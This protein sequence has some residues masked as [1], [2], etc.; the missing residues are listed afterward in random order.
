[1][2]HHREGSV[3]MTESPQGAENCYPDLGTRADTRVLMIYSLANR[4]PV[5][6]TRSIPLSALLAFGRFAP[7]FVASDEILPRI[8]I[9]ELIADPKLRVEGSLIG[10]R[11][12]SLRMLLAVTPR[13]DLVL[14]LD[15]SISPE[16]DATDIADLLASTCFRRNRLS[17]NTTSVLAIVTAELFRR[18]FQSDH[19]LEFGRD[20][21]QI[22]YP[23]GK[24]L[25]QLIPTGDF[26]NDKLTQIIY[27]GTI[28]SSGTMRAPLELNSPGC[29]LVV[30]G[31]G[32]SVIGGWAPHV[33]NSLAVIAATLVSTL[34]VIQRTRRN[35]F[36][37]LRL[38]EETF[39]K[40]TNEARELVSQLSARLADMQLDLSFGVEAYIDSVLVP[41]LLV[42]SFQASLRESVDVVNSLTNTSRMVERL[43][44]V[45][46]ARW[47]G[48]EAN[49][50]AA[51]ERREKVVS[52][53][54][55]VVTLFAL[56]PAL[57][58]SFFGVSSSDLNPRTSILDLST[59]WKAYLVA[60]IP[61]VMIVVA[62]SLLLRRIG[63]FGSAR[64]DS[65]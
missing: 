63:R 12:T 10:H 45:I 38:N 39:L 14:A 5:E 56:P 1:M 23:S 50:Q 34:G 62:G 30:H 54:I 18:G 4:M 42:E 59:Y 19:E 49:F 8:A 32:V 58:L 24:L 43:Q 22:V 20:V 16:V 17:V 7:H 48:L 60:W 37:A 21:H 57:L 28:Q 3:I 46:D 29:T 15:L 11:V 33:E 65:A 44:S 6:S 2:T 25:D 64:H 31:R 51:R 47:S 55:A 41:E 53:V 9:N 35:A 13:A 36:R 40:S 26:S 52:Y 27:R 61:F